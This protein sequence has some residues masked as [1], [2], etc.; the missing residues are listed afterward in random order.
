MSFFFTN[1][2]IQEILRER[3]R[4]K[5]RFMNV[6]TQLKQVSVIIS[7][8]SRQDRTYARRSINLDHGLDSFGNETLSLSTR[9]IEKRI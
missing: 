3:E 7:N 6:K 1:R 4:E 9:G 5:Q 2:S 8:I